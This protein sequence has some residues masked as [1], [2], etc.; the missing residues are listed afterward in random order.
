[1]KGD[2]SAL[3][4]LI[5]EACHLGKVNKI[6]AGIKKLSV[7]LENLKC[8]HQGCLPHVPRV[9]SATA[10]RLHPFNIKSKQEAAPAD[11]PIHT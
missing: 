4:T 8:A 3:A 11:A 7:P 5:F 10:L 9:G 6:Q 1:M 2:T